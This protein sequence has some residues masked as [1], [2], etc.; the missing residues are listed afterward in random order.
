MRLP[1]KLVRLVA[2]KLGMAKNYDYVFW[3]T[4]VGPMS[5]KTSVLYRLVEG[6]YS[7]SHIATIGVDLKICIFEIDGKKIKLLIWDTS[8]RECF[9]DVTTAYCQNA[10]GIMLMYNTS[11]RKFFRSKML[12]WIRRI[13]ACTSG[14]VRMLVGNMCDLEEK[15][16][17]STVEGRRAAETYGME[18]MEVSAKT[19][20][21]VNREFYTL[22]RRCLLQY[23]SLAILRADVPEEQE[24][25]ISSCETGDFKTTLKLIR[26]SCNPNTMGYSAPLHYACMH[27]EPI[28]TIKYL[29]ET[30]DIDPMSKDCRGNTVLHIAAQH[31]RG[32]IIYYLVNEKRYSPC[33]T[34]VDGY[35]CLYIAC[36]A[37]HSDVAKCLLHESK[38]DVNQKDSFGRSCLLGAC[39]CGL[40]DV[41][42]Y[43]ISKSHCDPCSVDKYGE[44]CL[45]LAL[46]AG[47]NDVVDYLL[48]ETECSIEKGSELGRECLLQAC[49]HGL[50]NAVKY[51]VNSRQYDPN[52]KDKI[53]GQSCLHLACE[54]GHENIVSYLVSERYCNPNEKAN[55]GQNCL[56]IACKAGKKDI[57]LS[58]TKCDVS[59][60]DVYGWYPL[61]YACQTGLLCIA[62]HLVY[63]RQCNPNDKNKDGQ[64][65]LHVACMSGQISVVQY[66]LDETAC[67]IT[68]RDY[69]G[70]TCLHVACRA[71]QIDIVKY[72]VNKRKC[73][74]NDKTFNGQN[75]LHLAIIAYT[76]WGTGKQNK[77]D[78]VKFLISCTNPNEK[79]KYGESCLHLAC[80]EGYIDIVKYL[81]NE[82]HS[83][84]AITNSQGQNCLHIACQNGHKR[85]VEFLT[86]GS[87]CNPNDKDKWG[88]N[89]LHLACRQ[90]HVEI[91]MYL[92]TINDPLCNVN[93]EDPDG[94]TCL[95]W[96]CET[97]CIDIAEYLI[98]KRGC[99]LDQN[100][101]EVACALGDVDM[102]RFLISHGHCDPFIRD[103]IGSTLLHIASQ[104]GLLVSVVQY[105]VQ[106]VGLDPACIDNLGQTPLHH[107]ARENHVGLTKYLCSTGKIDISLRDTHGNT[108]LDL[109]QHREVILVLIQHG[110]NPGKSTLVSLNLQ[111]LEK[112]PEPSVS[113]FIVGYPS[114]GKTTLIKAL[115]KESSGLLA[116]PGFFFNVSTEPHTAGIIPTDFVSKIYGRVTFFDLAGQNQYYGSHAAVIQNS[117]LSA[118]V[119]LLVVKLP[120]MEEDIKQRILYWLTFIENQCKEIVA[121]PCV[122][123]VGSHA[124]RSQAA[125]EP[126]RRRIWE[127]LQAQCFSNSFVLVD[128]IP[129]DCRKSESSGM[130][131]LRRSLKTSCSTLRTEEI[132]DFD[133]HCLLVFLV[134][135][136]ST[137]CAITVK[138][139]SEAVL[140]EKHMRF[141]VQ[142][143]YFIQPDPSFLFQMCD[144]LHSRGHILFLKNDVDVENSWVVISKEVLLS[145]ITGTIFAPKEFKEHREDL[146]SSTGVVPLT[147]L[148]AHFPQFDSEMITQC[149]SLLEFCHEI[150]D[151]EIL[152]L[153][154]DKQ[155]TECEGSSSPATQQHSI[156]PLTSERYFFFPALV[157]MD[158]PI[159]QLWEDIGFVYHSGWVL[160][161]SQPEHFFPPRFLQVLLL[162]L[163]FSFALTPD[164]H[165]IENDLPVLRRK[166]LVWKNYWASMA[167]ITSLVELDEQSKV[168]TFIVRCLHSSEIKCVEL[169][170][171]VIQK[172]LKAVKDFCPKVCVNELLIHPADFHYPLQ[173]IRELTTFSIQAVA[174]AVSQAQPAV[175]NNAQK[176]ITVEKL[177]YFEPYAD[178][179]ERILSE[180][181][182][183]QNSDYATVVSDS[184]LYAIADRAH[185]KRAFFEK[186]LNLPA[187]SVEFHQL[188]APPGSAHAMG[189]LLVCWKERSD[190]SRQCLRQKLDQ[191]SIFA[192]RN[193][194]VSCACM[195]SHSK[196]LLM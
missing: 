57:L 162:R 171:A 185:H 145:Q 31:G 158:P 176:L 119:F 11:D 51:L 169:R 99:N 77:Y 60:K 38:C 27:C 84:P 55:N 155:P 44:N 61:Q 123:I 194:L 150:S 100:L 36:K 132:M 133:C 196:S 95:Q 189:H 29:V 96:A 186:L 91:V 113:I 112:R 152:N 187:S 178:M 184:F 17:V 86:T 68:E 21:N 170:S 1:R 63:K 103:K 110:A 45:H 78:V 141:Q 138:Q 105:L 14:A 42:K 167:V 107:A 81:V 18:F 121:K 87:H 58:E 83:T 9:L 192:G 101:N 165:Q 74:P 40:I 30:C 188:R 46:K 104:K 12:S 15:R 109:A 90:Y 130:T 124:D 25:M 71:H 19:G 166:C 108:A 144:K 56:H 50:L 92:I 135:K 139:L 28:E 26:K 122:I 49:K 10:H 102:A 168:V 66:L 175:V 4:L 85:I 193:P 3:L 39:N 190:G 118:A 127:Y 191:F 5:G 126:T 182:D 89:S 23:N 37:G 70:S 7:D 22:A 173:P 76:P 116:L 142:Y 143:E 16:E 161:C 47:H 140:K 111:L 163:A 117:I 164:S 120:E 153:I 6:R 146:A 24:K 129:L 147:H 41:V 32:D 88:W 114:V 82:R 160:Q 177:L 174:Q 180:L 128:F 148:A 125:E 106:E 79:N 65:C 52:C 53:R 35:D 93:E 73:N 72:L 69:S 20:F 34:N 67:C 43:L 62:K 13:E 195:M 172:I 64:N 156:S 149:L 94:R 48:N 183:V 136:F 54:A 2:Q 151:A 181:F 59:R 154:T 159:S 75:C 33:D 179:D 80:K 137:V 8:G 131:Q 115:T 157:R 98:T 134:Q 97:G